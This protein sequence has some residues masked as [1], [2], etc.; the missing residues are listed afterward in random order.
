MA[1]IGVSLLLLIV[2][3]CAIASLQPKITVLFDGMSWLENLC[4]DTSASA[5]FMSEL[6]LGR[7]W[8]VQGS[9]GS[10]VKTLWIDGNV[11]I[12]MQAL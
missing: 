2:S 6:K 5:L 12:A 4:F 7:V 1:R 11:H 10:Y 3:S 9:G 8:K